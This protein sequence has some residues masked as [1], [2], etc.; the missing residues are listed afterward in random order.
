MDQY[1]IWYISAS[2][3]SASLQKSNEIA[4][5][6][7]KLDLSILFRLRDA[8]LYKLLKPMLSTIQGA[9][10]QT[11]APSASSADPVISLLGTECIAVGTRIGYT[12]IDSLSLYPAPEFLKYALIVSISRRGF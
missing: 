3:I 12:V 1:P 9:G 10:L 4:G 7:G 5:D 11:L 6:K 8:I 2:E